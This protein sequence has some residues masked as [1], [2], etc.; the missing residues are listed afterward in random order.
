M[1]RDADRDRRRFELVVERGERQAPPHRE[2]QIRRI[3]DG[4]VL[5]SG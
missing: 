4:E 2:F 5:C 1:K 3:V